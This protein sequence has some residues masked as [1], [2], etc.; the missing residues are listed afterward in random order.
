[1]DKYLSAL[2]AIDVGNYFSQDY[3]QGINFSELGETYYSY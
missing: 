2:W 3:F 1:M